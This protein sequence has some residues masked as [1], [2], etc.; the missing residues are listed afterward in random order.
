MRRGMA[1]SGG[2]SGPLGPDDVF[3]A[4]QHGQKEDVVAVKDKPCKNLVRASMWYFTSCQH[5]DEQ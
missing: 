3:L 1:L 2:A 5:S 4:L